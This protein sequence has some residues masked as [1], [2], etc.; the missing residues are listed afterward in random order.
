MTPAP[1]DRRIALIGSAGSLVGLERRLADRGWTP[2]RVEA[3]RTESVRVRSVPAWLRRRPPADLWIVTSRA[4]V[5]TFLAGCPDWRRALRTIPKVIAVGP[6]TALALRRNR[7]TSLG[8]VT[9]G[10]SKALL[11]GLGPVAGLRIVYLRS[12]LAGPDLAR[13]LRSRGARV[14]DRVV[15]RTRKA[16]PLPRALRETVGSM[17][18]WIVTSPSALAGFRT[19]VGRAVFGQ[20]R[21]TTEGFAL[22]AR[23][24]RAMRR[25][26]IRRVTAPNES[27]EEG[28]TRLL[29]KT[30]GDASRQSARRSR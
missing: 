28:F 17:P 7:V 18:I 30:L 11:A 2:V 13:R 20:Y 29:E 10:G 24:A 12:D 26:G 21:G 1:P 8:R 22:G 25:D 9:R 19:M 4:V 23:T 27:T 16:G 14:V 15:Y 6:D 5:T 3:V